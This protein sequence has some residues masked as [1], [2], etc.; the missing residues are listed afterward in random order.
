MSPEPDPKIENPPE[1]KDEQP[2]P[3]RR[4]GIDD[5]PTDKKTDPWGGSPPP[6]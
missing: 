5:N 1:T 3:T 6:G 4:L 2:K